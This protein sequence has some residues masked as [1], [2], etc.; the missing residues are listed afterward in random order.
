MHLMPKAGKCLFLQYS[1]KLTAMK[2]KLNA[3]YSH[4]QIVN[5]EKLEVVHI[6]TWRSDTVELRAQILH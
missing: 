1:S 3:E 5:L 4:Q 2:L 6:G